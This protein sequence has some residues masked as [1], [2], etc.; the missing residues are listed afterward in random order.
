M[1][2]F[3]FGNILKTPGADS[4]K[5]FGVNLV[6]LYCRIS[7]P[8]V[9]EENAC[10]W[11]LSYCHTIIYHKQTFFSFPVPAAVA[12]LYRIFDLGMSGECSTTVLLPSSVNLITLSFIQEF[13][14]VKTFSLSKYWLK[15]IFYN[16]I[17][18][19]KK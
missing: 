4:I 18:C 17:F 8:K 7:N 13:L 6:T 19:Y 1:V 10:V 12:R 14:N 2:I 3:H 11:L 16:K 15:K 5:L 9:W